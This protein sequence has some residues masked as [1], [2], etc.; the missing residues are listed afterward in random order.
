MD[1]VSLL[2]FFSFVSHVDAEKSMSAFYNQQKSGFTSIYEARVAA[3]TQNLFPMVFGR[4]NSAGMDD[5]EYLPAVQDPDKLDNGI[6]GLRYQISRGMGDVKFQLESAIDSIMGDYLEARQI[7][8]LCL[9]K[10]K[11]FMSDLCTFITQNFQKWQHRG[12]SKK[13][14]WQMTTVCVRPI[15]EEIHSQRVVARDVLDINDGDFSCAKY[16]W[17]TWKADA[18][19]SSKIASLEKAIKS[20]NGRMDTIQAALEKDPTKGGKF[21]QGPPKEPKDE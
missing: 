21:K 14:S 4:S 11:R 16:L 10:A 6:T 18:A 9:Y 12:H 2:D 7:A 8:K 13:D 1:A 19:Q 15:F 5:S 17:V 3:S 20:I